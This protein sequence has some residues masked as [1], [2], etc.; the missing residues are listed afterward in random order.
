MLKRFD[1]I[2]WQEKIC[3]SRSKR[4]S[5]GHDIL[6][7]IKSIMK[8]EIRF[9]SSQWQKV[10]KLRFIYTVYIILIIIKQISTSING[11]FKGYI[12]KERELTTWLPMK[13][14]LLWC[15]IYL[16]K[17]IETFT[18]NS[19]NVIEESL[20]NKNFCKF[21]IRRNSNCRKYTSRFGQTS[22]MALFTLQSPCKIPGQLS[23]A[24]IFFYCFVDKLPDF[25]NLFK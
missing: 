2:K 17:A 18:V 25:W 16:A 13:I 12:S 1:F 24:L 11:L 3:H 7:F 9:L 10:L 20:E 5:H 8:N 23:S 22:V 14:L 15:A 4:R 19:L 21:V 6:L